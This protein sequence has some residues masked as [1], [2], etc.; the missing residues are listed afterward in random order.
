[1]ASELETRILTETT[2]TIQGSAD[3]NED[4]PEVHLTLDD[5]GDGFAVL[6]YGLEYVE[7]DVED[8]ER[9]IEVLQRAREVVSSLRIG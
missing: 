1:M 8:L 6:S 7:F 5:D 3:I 9:A 4:L 2:V